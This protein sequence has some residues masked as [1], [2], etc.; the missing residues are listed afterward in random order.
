MGNCGQNKVDLI[1]DES[2]VRKTPYRVYKYCK[3]TLVSLTNEQM[4][5]ILNFCKL[6]DVF[7]IYNSINF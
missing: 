6:K 4:N 1:L 5:Q 3:K 2:A 7:I